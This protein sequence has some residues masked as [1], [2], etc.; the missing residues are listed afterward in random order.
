M[1]YLEKA[2]RFTFSG[3]VGVSKLAGMKMYSVLVVLVH[4][5]VKSG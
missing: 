4:S 2:C 1:Q 3:G 5:V